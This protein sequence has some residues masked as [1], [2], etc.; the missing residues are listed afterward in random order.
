MEPPEQP[1]DRMP[2]V[3]AIP[4]DRLSGE[5][6]AAQALSPAARTTLEALL[7]AARAEARRHREE[8]C[9]ERLNEAKGYIRRARERG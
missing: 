3:P 2:T 4:E 7:M 8:D 5:G 9:F 6:K 1:R